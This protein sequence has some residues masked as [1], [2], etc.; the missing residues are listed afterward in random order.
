MLC[1]Q[2]SQAFV[3]SDWQEAWPLAVPRK[4][5]LSEEQGHVWNFFVWTPLM[6]GWLAWAGG[7]GLSW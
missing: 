3:I 6:H 2:L 4:T 5:V 1:T 7:D